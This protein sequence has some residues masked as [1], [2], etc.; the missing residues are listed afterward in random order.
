M[1]RIMI[2]LHFHTILLTFYYNFINILLKL[3]F[4]IVLLR[5]SFDFITIVDNLAPCQQHFVMV[6]QYFIRD[7]HM[8]T[9]HGQT[10]YYYFISILLTFYYDFIMILLTFYYDFINILLWFYYDILSICLLNDFSYDN[11]Y[12]HFISDFN[13]YFIN[14]LLTFY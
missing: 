5:F 14:I 1:I 9:W 13:Y 3:I 12:W 6:L 2:L 4:I 11:F 7:Y 10:F 8:L